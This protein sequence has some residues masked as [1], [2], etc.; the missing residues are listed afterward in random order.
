MASPHGLRELHPRA[1]LEWSLTALDRNIQK[2]SR[3]SVLESRP[4]APRFQGPPGTDHSV[5]YSS[6]PSRT[7]TPRTE[8]QQSG[9]GQTLSSDSIHSLGDTGKNTTPEAVNPVSLLLNLT[10]THF[11]TGTVLL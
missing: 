1:Q 4:V 2:L 10:I 5:P 7:D 6:R 9:R 8:W 3:F 11:N